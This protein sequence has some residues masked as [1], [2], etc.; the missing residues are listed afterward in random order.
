M[1]TKKIGIMAMLIC[2]LSLSVIMVSCFGTG[3]GSADE[4]SQPDESQ[5]GSHDIASQDTENGGEN[6][7][8]FEELSEEEL[9]QLL[10]YEGFM[11]V[12]NSFCYPGSEIQEV[13]QMEDDE[14]LLYI[15]LESTENSEEIRDYYKEK[16]VQSIWSRSVI[17]EESAGG[18][19]EEFIE[20]EDEDIPVYKFTYSSNDKDK[21]V[22]VLIKGLEEGRTWIMVLYWN[23]Q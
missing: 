21:V 16:K 1:K 11:K 3:G 7:G 9:N 17:Y 23:L 8:D 5:L 14:N 13:K 22:N 15:L 19:E 4:I 20:E 12:F 2:F 10:E 18:L 6:D